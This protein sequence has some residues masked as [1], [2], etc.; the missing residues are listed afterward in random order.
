MEAE[1]VSKSNK[2]IDTKHQIPEISSLIEKMVDSILAS[3]HDWAEDHI[4]TSKDDVEEVYNFLMTKKA[5]TSI[6]EKELSPKQKKIAAAAPPED[7]ITGADFT[8]LRARS[9][10]ENL[11]FERSA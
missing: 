1:R 10:K 8:A 5:P 3:G 4:S 7:K 6:D 11:S 2:Q 9:L